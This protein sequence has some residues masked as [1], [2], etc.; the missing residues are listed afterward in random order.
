MSMSPPRVLVATL[1]QRTNEK[2][3][4]YLTGLPGKARLIGFRDDTLPEGTPTWQPIVRP[5]K[6]Q[7][8]DAPGGTQT[9]RRWRLAGGPPSVGAQRYQRPQAKKPTA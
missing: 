6:K 9:S 1:W 7:Q 5:A 3:N 2:G 8:E 4:A